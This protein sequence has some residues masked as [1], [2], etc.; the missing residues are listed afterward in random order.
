MFTG[1]IKSTGT[2]KDIRNCNNIKRLRIELS[3]PQNWQI[4]NGDS[5]DIDGVCLT[6]TYTDQLY[7]CVDVMPETLNRTTLE[8]IKIGQQVNLEPALL[9]TERL[10]GHFVLGHVDTTGS[11]LNIVRDQETINLTIAF[12]SKYFPYIVEKGSIAINGVSLTVTDVQPTNF[13]VKLIPYTLKHTNLGSLSKREKV[14][15][16]TD[17]IGKYLVHLQ[18]GVIDEK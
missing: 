3:Q 17:I 2:I 8:Q 1:E 5:I 16:E 12:S 6:V 9:A 15:L 7:I 14:N 18:E 10:A 4:K 11:V 13:T